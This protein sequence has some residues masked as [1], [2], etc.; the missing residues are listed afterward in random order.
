MIPI[1][2]KWMLVAAIIIVGIA[3][4]INQQRVTSQCCQSSL[5]RLFAPQEAPVVAESRPIM[6]VQQAVPIV[7][8]NPTVTV[9][10]P[11]VVNQVVPVR[12]PVTTTSYY[13]NS[14]CACSPAPTQCTVTKLVPQ[15][16]YH[17]E[18]VTT[19]ETVY[20]EETRYRTKT[21]SR[22]VPETTIKTETVT[23]SRPVWETIEKEVYT[24]KVTYVPETSE[25]EEI[26]T[27]SVPV[28]EMREKKIVEKVRKPIQTT[29]MKQRTVTVNREINS[30]RTELKDQGRYVTN[31]APVEPK[32]YT[33]LAWFPGGD[34]YNAATGTTRY[35]LPGF[36][37]TEMTGPQ[38]YKSSKIWQSNLVETQVPVTTIVPE[39][40]TENYPVCETT[41]QDEEIVRTE[42]VP[43]TTY[44]QEQIVKKIPVTTYKP[45][46]ERIVQKIPEKVCRI[47]KKEEIREIPVTTYKTVCEV[48]QEP[49]TVKVARTVPKKIKVQRPV[50]TY[51]KVTETIS[52]SPIADAPCAID[53]LSLS[54]TI[55]SGTNGSSS[56]TTARPN[57]PTTSSVTTS[58]KSTTIP[59]VPGSATTKVDAG[60]VQP[61]LKSESTDNGVTNSETTRTANRPISPLVSSNEIQKPVKLTTEQTDP[62]ENTAS[63]KTASDKTA[64]VKT[65]PIKSE[66]AK[67][68]VAPVKTES[69]KPG[70]KAVEQ[71]HQ[72]TVNPIFHSESPLSETRVSHSLNSA[73]PTISGSNIAAVPTIIQASHT[74]TIANTQ[75]EIKTT[76]NRSSDPETKDLSKLTNNDGQK[77][78]SN[79]TIINAGHE[80]I[81]GA[82]APIA[83]A[84]LNTTTAPVQNKV[85]PVQFGTD[86]TKSST[87][88]VPPTIAPTQVL[89]ND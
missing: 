68:E 41:W 50:T 81:K 35:R 26:Q 70:E 80:E 20:E 79:P 54:S 34:Y 48:I 8:Q 55:Y 21:V 45:V 25:R 57:T 28:T 18:E 89:S 13:P 10:R 60:S 11:A 74:E 17:E 85:V 40:V 52:G 23:V 33:R 39:T 19:Y 47:E 78:A 36:Y 6:P 86:Q 37:W 87:N 61:S 51:K 7:I 2:K 69:V 49:Y 83:T 38:Q 32:S 66:P 42:Q 46:T 1:N 73:A 44:K 56:S 59:A 77:P 65:E 31:Y 15:T 53:T 71:T 27:V 72:T 24:D 58:Q 64:P 29:V 5:T 22:Q 75:P 3:A 63:D 30:V 82:T 12:Q 76:E 14:S 4:V 67:N 16:E 84:E 88:V 62:V 9:A 43:V